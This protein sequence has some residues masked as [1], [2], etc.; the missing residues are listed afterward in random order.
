MIE[1]TGKNLNILITTE[2]GKDWQT[3]MSW[4]SVFKNAPDAK[5]TI[6]CQRNKETPFQLYQWAKKVNVP[7]VHHDPFAKEPNDPFF[8]DKI[9]NR[10]NAIKI[11]GIKE[12]LLVLSPLVIIAETFDPKITEVAELFDEK[13]WFLQR[14]NIDE[15]IDSH[16]LE[17]VNIKQTN[18]VCVEAKE[19]DEPA[20][21]VS[22]KKGCGKWID[23][24]KGCPFSNA[25]G[26][27]LETMTINEH[28]IIDLWKKLCP[29]YSVL[30]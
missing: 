7:V 24:S 10:L 27:A 21:L 29:L 16:V 8:Q 12:N 9:L 30:V 20:C 4:Y 28:R 19:C 6:A 17:G 2:P 3:F 25:A 15:R 14:V 18:S 26:L 22:L 5:V 23:T 1:E 11:S 13:V